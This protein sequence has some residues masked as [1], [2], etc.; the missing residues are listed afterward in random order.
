ME[1]KY[2]GLYLANKLPFLTFLLLS[3]SVKALKPTREKLL[4][5]AISCSLYTR[6]PMQKLMSILLPYIIQAC[7]VVQ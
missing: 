2:A 3:N 6:S 1:D 7:V 4:G 5:E